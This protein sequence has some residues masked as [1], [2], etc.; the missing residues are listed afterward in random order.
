LLSTHRVML[1]IKVL[2]EMVGDREFCRARSICALVKKAVRFA[3]DCWV[4][5]LGLAV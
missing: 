3:A 2:E 5:R 1:Q 4:V